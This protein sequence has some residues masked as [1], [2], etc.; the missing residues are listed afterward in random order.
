M[1][2]LLSFP[3]EEYEGRLER[4]RNVMAREEIDLLV[5]FLLLFLAI[6]SP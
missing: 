3:H 4:V 1:R 5:F 2:K 6:Q